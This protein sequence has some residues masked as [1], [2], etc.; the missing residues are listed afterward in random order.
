MIS[1]AGGSINDL[2]GGDD[3]DKLNSKTDY[4]NANSF[5]T[6]VCFVK[7]TR[8]E[9][10]K[11][12]IA[13]EALR[14]GDRVKTADHGLQTIRWINSTSVP[15]F[16]LHAPVRIAAGALGNT[17][18]LW[19]SQQHRMLFFGA[20]VQLYFGESEVLVAAKHLAGLSGIE[21]IEL[22]RVEFFHMLFDR[23]EIVFSEGIPSES[24]YPG[25]V[26][27]NALSDASC[28]EIYSLFPELEASSGSFGASAR[29]VLKAYEAGVL[30]A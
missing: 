11:G 1:G 14:V 9:T 2:D 25:D 27:M 19:V 10:D 17:R 15:A 23:H 12:N 3:N 18:P 20:E 22:P 29:Y 5:E 7:G 16:G 6:I 24:F 13:I 30:A 8:I 21:I 26:G 28:A 4:P